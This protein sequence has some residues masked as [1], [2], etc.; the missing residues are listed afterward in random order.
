[1]MLRLDMRR[2]DNVGAARV[3]DDQLC[4][5]ATIL[6]A[7]PAFHPAGKN[8]M[9]I[10]RIGPDNQDDIAILNTVKILCSCAGSECGF[11]SVSRR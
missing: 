11:Q 6:P 9:A 2:A 4:R 3:D 8:R 7:Q 10:G 5:R 1:M